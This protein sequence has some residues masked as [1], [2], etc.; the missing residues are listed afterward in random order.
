MP[1]ADISL[2]PLKSGLGGSRFSA[3]VSPNY[4]ISKDSII[5]LAIPKNSSYLADVDV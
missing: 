5:S 4:E 3:Y 2:N 1:Y